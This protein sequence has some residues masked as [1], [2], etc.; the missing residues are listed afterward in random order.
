MD[1]EYEAVGAL[2]R[3]YRGPML[4]AS[5]AELLTQALGQSVTQGMVSKFEKGQ[6]WSKR[7][8]ELWHAFCEVL[9]IP[10]DEM[11]AALGFSLPGRPKGAPSLVDLVAKDPTLSKAAKDHLMNQYKLL[12]MASAQERAGHPILKPPRRRSG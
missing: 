9:S 2:V 11:V 4:Q 8:P 1:T 6:G 3:K 5:V 10:Q 7:G 12:Q